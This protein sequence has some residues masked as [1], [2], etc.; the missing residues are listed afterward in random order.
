MKKKKAAPNHTDLAEHRAAIEVPGE[1]LSM[2]P[3]EHKQ[4][5]AP[6]EQ[7]P[8]VH[9]NETLR[10]SDSL[11]SRMHMTAAADSGSS[12]VDMQPQ[13]ST[14]PSMPND[15][16]V[17]PT[18]VPADVASS[19]SPAQEAAAPVPRWHLRLQMRGHRLS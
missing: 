11:T 1:S 13:A 2:E 7:G 9:D 15:A 4:V 8:V 19:L 16:E 18:Q 17:A 5:E 10:N 6:T 3:T 14:T 12:A